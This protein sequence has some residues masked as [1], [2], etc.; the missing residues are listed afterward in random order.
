M[1]THDHAPAPEVQNRGGRTIREKVI[2]NDVKV[3]VII[4]GVGIEPMRW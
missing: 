4:R 3:V 2:S 1:Q